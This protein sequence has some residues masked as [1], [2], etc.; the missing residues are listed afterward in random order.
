MSND[1]H[2]DVVAAAGTIQ[3]SGDGEQVYREHLEEK[4]Q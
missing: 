1:P 3:A 4:Y 2:P